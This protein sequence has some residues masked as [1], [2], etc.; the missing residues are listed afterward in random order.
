MDSTAGTEASADTNC[1]R[2]I[3]TFQV[4]TLPVKGV[5]IGL[6]IHFIMDLKAMFSTYSIIINEGGP[7]L[8]RACE[9]FNEEVFDSAI[10]D[11]KLESACEVAKTA[12]WLHLSASAF[13][14]KILGLS[15]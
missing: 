12:I 8:R 1:Y 13:L 2:A 9:K 7:V 10:A 4:S 3:L 6:A 11:Q 5:I 14:W 15:E